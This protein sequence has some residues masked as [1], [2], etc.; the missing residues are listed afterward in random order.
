MNRFVV[1]DP[2]LCIG[3]RT[4]EIAC[5]LAHVSGE[6]VGA[7]DAADFHPRVKVLK[8]DE[9]SGAVMCRHCEDAPCA[10]VCPNGAIVRAGDQSIQVLQDKCIG[11]KMCVLACPY[12]AMTVRMQKVVRYVQE[13]AVGFVYKAQALKCD[14]CHSR[15]NGHGPA[16]VQACPT[17]A[18]RVMGDE[19]LLALQK[20]RQQAALEMAAVVDGSRQ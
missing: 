19:Q 8:E 12:G 18:L 14:L 9:V 17:D 3:C 10:S 11:C 6:Q 7:I 13:Q 5:V 4:C 1:C 20:Q 2:Q 15:A 16:C